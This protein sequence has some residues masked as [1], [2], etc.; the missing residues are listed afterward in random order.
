MLITCLAE[1]CG[2]IIGA[3]GSAL[4]LR[5]LYTEKVPIFLHWIKNAFQSELLAYLYFILID[6]EC[7]QNKS[8]NMN[9]L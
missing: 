1:L 7:L 5:L 8:I 4:G 6:L 3:C 9:D 2:V